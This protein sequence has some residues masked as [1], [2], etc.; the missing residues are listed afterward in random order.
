MTARKFSRRPRRVGRL[1]VSAALACVGLA[2][3]TGGEARP[4]PERLAT[5]RAERSELVRQFGSVQTRIRR[6]QAAA[7]AEPGPAA[8]RA[9]LYDEIR[10][11]AEREGPASAALLERALRVGA[12]LTRVS[13]PVITTPE[14]A[15]DEI[16]PPGEREDIARELAATERE[17]RPFVDR[18]MADPAVR[19][20]FDALR[21]TLTAAMVRID[22][23]VEA[24]LGRM[25]EIA[26]SIGR[27]ETEI[28]R[29]QGPR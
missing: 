18:A 6:T 17:L 21:D 22:P 24:S 28:A 27:I 20:R 25:E 11:F 1:P 2:A 19:A 15:S 16:V 3:C 7:L 4:D 29:E 9:A 12:D 14:G 8:A 26:D 5:L 13:T 10:R 23:G